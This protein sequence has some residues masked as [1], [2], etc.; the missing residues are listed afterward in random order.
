MSSVEPPFEEPGH[1]IRYFGK[2]VTD[3]VSDPDLKTRYIRLLDR[4][5]TLRYPF[6]MGTVVTAIDVRTGETTFS[7]LEP[8]T[9][10]LYQAFL[11][12]QP[13][14]FFEVSHPQDER[15]L[16]WDVNVSAIPEGVTAV[17]TYKESPYEAPV[18]SIWIPPGRSQYPKLNALVRMQELI[19]GGKSIIPAG[20]WLSSRFSFTH[21]EAS[22]EADIYDMLTKFKIPSTPVTFGGSLREAVR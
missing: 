11:G 8:S 21:V 12:V 13:G 18:F 5:K 9:R 14:A 7:D 3:P 19:A 2:N 10:H 6:K 22:K 1:Y 15:T 4:E 17:I 20:I 16:K